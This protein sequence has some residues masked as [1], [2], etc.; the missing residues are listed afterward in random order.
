[1]TTAVTPNPVAPAPPPTPVGRGEREQAVGRAQVVVWIGFVGVAVTVGLWIR[2][3]GAAS[4]TG[5]GGF[6][7][8]VGQLTALVG[9]YAVLVQ[10][11]LMS[12]IV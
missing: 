1:M 8:A 4:A 3:G 9:T 6:A 12:R 7:T 11:L 2:H 10:L 5:P